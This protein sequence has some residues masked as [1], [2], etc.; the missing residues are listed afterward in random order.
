MPFDPAKHAGI[1]VDE[2]GHRHERKTRIIAQSRAVILEEKIT[3][4]GG[5]V[6]LQV[7]GRHIRV[8]CQTGVAT[9]H[10]GLAVPTGPLFISELRNDGIRI[11]HIRQRRTVIHHNLARLGLGKIDLK[12]PR[13]RNV[14]V[15]IRPDNRLVNQVTLCGPRKFGLL[16]FHLGERGLLNLGVDVDFNIL[17]LRNR[18]LGVINEITVILGAK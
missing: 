15:H 6:S 9:D 3:P 16:D 7:T 1:P 17:K 13:I 2:H 14:G 11:K 10:P 8:G 18:V 12:L 4:D 5:L